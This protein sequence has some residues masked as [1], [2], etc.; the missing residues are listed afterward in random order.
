MRDALSLLDQAIA[1]GG[2]SV[3][4][5]GVRDMLGAVDE[6]YL[7]RLL[8]AVAAGD[9]PALA[10]IADEMQAR[11]L[12][13]DARA[14]GP[15]EPAAARSRWR[16]RCRRRWRRTCPSASASWR[17]PAARSGDGAA[18]LPDRDA[19]PRRPAARARRARR[20]PDD[21]CCACWCFVPE[22]AKLPADEAAGESEG[23]GGEARRS[24]RRAS[25]ATGRRW[26]SS[27]RSSG[28]AAR[29]G[30]QRRA[31]APAKAAVRPGGAEDE[32]LPRR[33]S[34]ARS[35]RPRCERT[36]APGAASSVSRRRDP[37][38]TAAAIESAENAA[39]G[40]AEAA[41]AVQG[42]RFVQDLVNLFDG[43]VVDSTIRE[44]QR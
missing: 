26:R 43:R 42:D 13:F 3:A 22:R 24:A 14:A 29:A 23:A 20:F 2:G 44:K 31:E 18:V 37:G 39:R 34:T 41:R 15:G 5:A 17:W 36:G 10:A 27:C 33:R 8:E 35:C 28:G 7:L 21:A 25:T 1:H 40:S 12:S 16:R 9:G 11:S 19:G 30:A 6:S 38:A 32:G 4:A